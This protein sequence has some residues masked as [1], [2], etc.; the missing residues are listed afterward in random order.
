MLIREHK[1]YNETRVCIFELMQG[2]AKSSFSRN[3]PKWQDDLLLE[4]A[5]MWSMGVSQLL[6]WPGVAPHY[7]FYLH[8]RHERWISLGSN[9]KS[10]FCVQPQSKNLL[11][12]VSAEEEY[13]CWEASGQ[14]SVVLISIS[15]RM[16][17]MLYPFFSLRTKKMICKYTNKNACQ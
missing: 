13:R 8:P 11:D 16:I 10:M 17:L 1:L 9:L 15:R 5:V 12:S 14:R 4:E 7:S 2:F 3:F 6:K